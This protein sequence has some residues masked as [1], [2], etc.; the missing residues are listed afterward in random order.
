MIGPLGVP[1]RA[2]LAAR[3]P[4]PRIAIPLARPTTERLEELAP[5][6]ASGSVTPILNLVFDFGD[7]AGAIRYLETEH[8]T[9]KV[10]MKVARTDKVG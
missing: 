5:L 8:A 2:Q 10:I 3:M 4:G 1:T 7:A 9:V 6:L